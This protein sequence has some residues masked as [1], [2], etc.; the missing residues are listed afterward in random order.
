MDHNHLD[1]GITDHIPVGTGSWRRG[2]HAKDNFIVTKSCELCT[3]TL[4]LYV[5]M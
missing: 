1:S 5:V 3:H 2:R 4:C